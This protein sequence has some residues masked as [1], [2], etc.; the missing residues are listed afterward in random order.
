[1]PNDF[2]LDEYLNCR[3]IF[4]G[5]AG[6]K[7]AFSVIFHGKDKAPSLSLLP[8][9]FHLDGRSE[10]P[11]VQAITRS[12][13]KAFA[14]GGD[15]SSYYLNEKRQFTAFAKLKSLPIFSLPSVKGSRQSI[16]VQLPTALLRNCPAYLAY[17][18]TVRVDSD[19]NLL[20]T[21]LSLGLKDRFVQGALRAR[22]FIDVVFTT[23]MTFFTHSRAV[24]RSQIRGIMDCG[25]AFIERISVLSPI[26]LFSSSR[27]SSSSSSEPP[28]CIDL[29]AKLILAK[30]S[31]CPSLQSEYVHITSR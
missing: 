29:I 15:D 4:K 19:P 5:Y 1:M 14:T 7:P 24:N 18:D 20:I 23:P 16:N 22:S 31:S 3:L 13:A 8:A 21:S 17:M 12:A 9:G 10:V 11:D 27:L 28:I 30:F 26:G 25:A 2:D 6:C